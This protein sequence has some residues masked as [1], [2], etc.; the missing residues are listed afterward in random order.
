MECEGDWCLV[1]DVSSKFRRDCSGLRLGVQAGNGGQQSGIS[2]VMSH[3]ERA[4]IQQA[5]TAS[6]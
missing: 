2:G 5:L 4:S 6:R 1:R 3:V